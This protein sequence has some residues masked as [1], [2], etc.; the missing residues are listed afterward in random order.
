MGVPV[1]PSNMAN[2]TPPHPRRL[3]PLDVPL[4]AEMLTSSQP[5]LPSQVSSSPGMVF[6]GDLLHPA[7]GSSKLVWMQNP[8]PK[9]PAGRAHFLLKQGFSTLSLH[10]KTWAHTLKLPSEHPP[11]CSAAKPS[12]GFLGYSCVCIFSS[13]VEGNPV[14]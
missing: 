2:L 14:S 13:R 3:R 1:T 11:T 8:S 6:W 5:H 12:K 4:H 10:R 9:T 7:M